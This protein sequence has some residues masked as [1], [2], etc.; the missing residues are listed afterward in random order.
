MTFIDLLP[1]DILIEILTNLNPI[2]IKHVCRINKKINHICTL[3]YLWKLKSFKDYPEFAN[4]QIDVGVE[5]YLDYFLTRSENIDELV[6]SFGQ[7]FNIDWRIYY[8]SLYTSIKYIPI[9][10]N[11]KQLGQ[12]LIEKDDDLT[13]IKEKV[14]EFMTGSKLYRLE[15]KNGKIVSKRV[16]A[17]FAHL[18]KIVLSDS[19]IDLHNLNFNSKGELRT[20]CQMLN[21]DS[22]GDKWVL[23]PRILAE[24]IVVLK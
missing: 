8:I 7:P 17:P 14:K 11:E 12:I 13:I 24:F 15:D 5:D 19:Y 6:S 18:S 3:E 23:K 20:I 22:S 2:D 16:R 9:Y 21:I 4:Q 1:K 10:L